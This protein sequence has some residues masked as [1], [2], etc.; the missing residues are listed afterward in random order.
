[1]AFTLAKAMP[2]RPTTP[3]V[4]EF[5]VIATAPAKA[6]VE[7]KLIVTVPVVPPT[8]LAGAVTVKPVAVVVAVT[9]KVS[10]KAALV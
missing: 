10:W 4:L 5:R 2:V 3:L 6:P 9:S 1:M 7:A 8:T